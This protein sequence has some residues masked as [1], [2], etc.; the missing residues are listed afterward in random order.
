MLHIKQTEEER[1]ISN[2]KNAKQ[3]WVKRNEGDKKTLIC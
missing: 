2:W 1:D 3:A